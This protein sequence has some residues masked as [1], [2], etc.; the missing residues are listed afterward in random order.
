[1]CCVSKRNIYR[2][3]HQVTADNQLL[4]CYTSSRY[5]TSQGE[6]CSTFRLAT[7]R[8]ML[9]WLSL[10]YLDEQQIVKEFLVYLKLLQSQEGAAICVSKEM[11][12]VKNTWSL[13]QFLLVT[14]MHNSNADGDFAR[15]WTV[16]DVG[17]EVFLQGQRGDCFFP[18]CS[19]K[20]EHNFSK[21]QSLFGPH[22]GA[23][24]SQV[25]ALKIV[26]HSG[27]LHTIHCF[28]L[29]IINKTTRIS[30]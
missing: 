23:C 11:I 18:Y 13:L 24:I 14:V 21:L 26:A 17:C 29:W 28:L 7:L 30:R 27:G 25:M 8:L 4:I 12:S 6:F 16:F 19:H 3:S 2:K 20:L 22:I 1:M 10:A 9:F 5:V 15:Q